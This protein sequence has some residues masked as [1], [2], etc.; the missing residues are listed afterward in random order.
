MPRSS[1]EKIQEKIKR[2]SNWPNIKKYPDIKKV[3]TRLLCTFGRHLD[4]TT[5]PNFNNKNWTLINDWSEKISEIL[6]T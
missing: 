4:N 6:R 1:R 2:K 3:Q 5:N